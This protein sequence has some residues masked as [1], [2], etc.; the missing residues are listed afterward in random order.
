MKT[1]IKL[2]LSLAFSSLLFLAVIMAFWGWSS[3]NKVRDLYEVNRSIEEIQIAFGEAI[4]SEKQFLMIEP[5]RSEFFETKTSVHLNDFGVALDDA[6]QIFTQLRENGYLKEFG[7]YD[8][9]MNLEAQVAQYRKLVMNDLQAS[10]MN[11][12]FKD[13]GAEGAL[14]EAIH[15]VEDSPFPYDRA[16]MLMLRRHEKDFFLRKDLKYLEK[17]NRQIESFIAQIDS[18]TTADIPNF[19]TEKRAV[20]N[21]LET[22]QQTFASIVE[23]TQVI[24]LNE[25]SGMLGKV[26]ALTQKTSSSLSDFSNEIDDNVSQAVTT[27]VSWFIG[28]FILMV[29]AGLLLTRIL[30]ILLSRPIVMMKDKLVTLSEGTFPEAFEDPGQDEVGQAK[31]G[32]QQPHGTHPHRF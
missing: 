11:R 16:Q 6:E 30:T 32:T 17:F 26:N 28:L 29:A 31:T 21:Y 2:K 23:V 10:I 24:G 15:A 22:Y 9:L 4:Q 8:K 27:T 14:R 5:S 13:H 19:A 25:Q 20:I 3:L 1:G 18:T 12:G 7:S